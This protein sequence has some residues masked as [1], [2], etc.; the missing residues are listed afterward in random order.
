MSDMTCV[1]EEPENM[2]INSEKSLPYKLRL[3]EPLQNSA[4]K[5]RAGIN[6]EFIVKRSEIR[7]IMGQEEI[8]RQHMV[9][10][11]LPFFA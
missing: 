1:H 9:H 8:A 11:P 3:E 2:A 5:C 10:Y 6:L 7:W 4:Y